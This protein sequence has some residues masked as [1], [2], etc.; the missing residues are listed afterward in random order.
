MCVN[1]PRPLRN[2]GLSLSLSFLD[3]DEA[4][5]GCC[6]VEEDPPAEPADEAELDHDCCDNPELLSD[7]SDGVELV[8]D[9]LGDVEVD[10][11][12]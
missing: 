4:L 6:S 9:V 2:N 11:N 12:C 1:L 7:W 3:S 10:D 8:C 5:N